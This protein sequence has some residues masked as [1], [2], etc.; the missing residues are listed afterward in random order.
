MRGG[1]FRVGERIQGAE[2]AGGGVMYFAQDLRGARMPGEDAPP[3]VKLKI[4]SLQRSRA[5]RA[6]DLLEREASILKGGSGH[7]VLTRSWALT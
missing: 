1:R 2:S 7:K 3:V 5:W 6:V 4:V